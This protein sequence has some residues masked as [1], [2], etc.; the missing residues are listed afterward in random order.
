[1]ETAGKL[2]TWVHLLHTLKS[3]SWPR[4]E[5]TSTARTTLKLCP[6]VAVTVYRRVT[7]QVFLSSVSV[8]HGGGQRLCRKTN[9]I[10]LLK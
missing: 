3:F 6:C 2:G 10:W 9:L 8:M 1:M 7:K 4:P 5:P